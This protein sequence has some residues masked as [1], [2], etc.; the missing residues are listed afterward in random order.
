M[1]SAFSLTDTAASTLLLTLLAINMIALASLFG[2]AALEYLGGIAKKPN[3]DHNGHYSNSI[4]RL[5]LVFTCVMVVVV[6]IA[7]KLV[8]AAG[9][10][11]QLIAA[12]FVGQGF[13]L[14]GALRS[15]I[16]GIVARYDSNVQRAI[17]GKQGNVTYAE[18][19]G[20]VVN[21]NITTFTIRT[22]D[23][24]IV[25]PWEKVHDLIIE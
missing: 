5:Q 3:N 4:I 24:Y 16:A 25:L 12:W 13:A 8:L 19:T 1:G 7:I 14:Q 2:E 18:R 6:I 17:L 20:H 23:G 22:K 9:F 21:C 10:A 15:I 11:D